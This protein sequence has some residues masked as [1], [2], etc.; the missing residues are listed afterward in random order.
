MN[1]ELLWQGRYLA[2]D[3]KYLCVYVVRGI[4][5]SLFSCSSPWFTVWPWKFLQASN[6][7]IHR[8]RIVNTFTF[9]TIWPYSVDQHSVVLYARS[10]SIFFLFPPQQKCQQQSPFTST[11]EPLWLHLQFI[12]CF[13]SRHSRGV[14][15]CSN[16]LGV[17]QSP[18]ET[19]I[20]TFVNKSRKK[21]K[22]PHANIT[23]VT[24]S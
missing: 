6:V 24:T 22:S 5:E 20:F 12:S 8:N 19:A 23:G 10:E 17:N 11:N 14:S 7:H 2:Y 21:D 9:V 13:L 15:L 1:I 4:K 18:Q 16:N 3:D